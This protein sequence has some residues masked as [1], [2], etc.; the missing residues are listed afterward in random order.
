MKIEG[1]IRKM[2]TFLANG[3]A[4]YVL[5]L[6]DNEINMNALLGKQLSFNYS[7]AIFCVKCGAK[8]KT[9]FF[10]GFCYNC[11]TTAPEA[12]DCVLKPELCKAHIGIARDMEYAQS[13]C[14]IP[15]YV[16]L[17]D[18]GSVKVG[19][20]RSNQIPTRWIDQGAMSAIIFAQTPNRY[21]AGQIEVEVMK[22]ISDKTNWRK[23]LAQT[24]PDT[25]L[26]KQAFESI[27]NYVSQDLQRYL[28]KESHIQSIKYPGNVCDGKIQSVNF[29][30]TPFF[31]GVLRGIK[32]QYLIFDSN[33]VLNIRKFGGYH[34][35]CTIE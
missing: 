32:G 4:N 14:L 35:Q 27:S 16:Y 21:T 28:L 26:L 34:I 11:F 17:A 18:T 29:D 6:A 24:T 23:M 13:H 25:V 20:T 2:R 12:E 1:D 19:V 33:M 31:T 30:K 22:N 3:I 7:G 10:Q 9:S 5:T 8:T 15:Q